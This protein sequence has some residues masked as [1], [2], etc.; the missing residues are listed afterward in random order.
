MQ[1]LI[2]GF[3]ARAKSL[4]KFFADATGCGG[5]SSMEGGFSAA[6]W[7]HFQRGMKGAYPLEAFIMPSKL[8]LRLLRMLL[9]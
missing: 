6:F 8:L 2:R 5:G 3:D 9:L 7:T 4:R 1:R